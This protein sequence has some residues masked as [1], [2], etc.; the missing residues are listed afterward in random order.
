[1]YD[2]LLENGDKLAKLTITTRV[3]LNDYIYMRKA[4]LPTLNGSWKAIRSLVVTEHGRTVWQLTEQFLNSEEQRAIGTI[5]PPV[6]LI[7]WM[8]QE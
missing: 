1:M 2:Y 5:E 6:T 8:T 3:D 4:H 7:R